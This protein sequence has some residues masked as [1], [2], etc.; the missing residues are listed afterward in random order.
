MLDKI[1][2]WSSDIRQ[3]A[4]NPTMRALFIPLLLMSLCTVAVAAPSADSWPRWQAH[5]KTSDQ[6]IDH[7]TFD[8]FLQTYVVTHA[9]GPNGV[10]YGAVSKSDRQKLTRYIDQMEKLDIASYNR[11]VQRAYWINLYNAETLALVLKAYPVDSIKQVDGG[12]FNRGPWNKKVLKVD[13]VKLSLNDVEHRILRPIWAD[14]MTHYGVNCASISCPSL[15]P[16]AYTGATVAQKLRDNARAYINSQQGVSIS[17]QGDVTVS[18]IYDWYQADFGGDAR[19]VIQHLRR[20]AKPGLS[21]RLDSIGTI[22]D[23]HYDWKL[24]SEANVK[25]RRKHQ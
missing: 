23:Y 9:H 15:L 18:S 8:D 6:T 3:T 24:N 7:S 16:H 25:K 12:L 4:E 14:G 22:D 19:G 17:K 20:F 11:S 13:G 5:D 2:R 21:A 1:A 10:R